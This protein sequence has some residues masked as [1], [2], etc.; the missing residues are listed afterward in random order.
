VKPAQAHSLLNTIRGAAENERLAWDKWEAWYEADSFNYEGEPIS[1]HAA[2]FPLEDGDSDLKLQ[3]NYPYA[4]LDT[5]V[6]TVCPQNPQVTISTTQEASKEAAKAREI[7]INATFKRGNLHDVLWDSSTQTGICGRCPIKTVWSTSRQMPISMWVNP[8]AFFFDMS[9]PYKYT[10]YVCE[11]VCITK[12]E[13]D[14]RKSRDSGFKYNREV[15]KYATGS[16]YPSWL[17][18]MRGQM[19]KNQDD[20]A[21]DELEWVLIYEFYDFAANQFFHFL[22]DNDQPLLHLKE[23]P[24]KYVRNPYTLQVFNKS[25]RNSGGVSD[26]KLIAGLLDRLNE[27]ETIE[28]NHAH[29][30]YPVTLLNTEGLDDPQAAIDA[31]R[32]AGPDD[33]VPMGVHDSH[34]FADV[35]ASTATGAGPLPG[36]AVMA[37]KISGKMDFIL[38]TP[39]YARGKTGT[40]DVATELALV[41]TATRTRNGRREKIMSDV[42]IDIAK[43][44]GGLWQQF[45]PEK[46]QIPIKTDADIGDVMILDRESLGF[47]DPSIA[48]DL[49][50]ENAWEETWYFDFDVVPFSPT[51]NHRLVQLNKLQTFLPYLAQNPNVNKQKFDLKLLELLGM[52]ELFQPEGAQM[53]AAAMAQ[54]QMGATPQMA[55]ATAGGGSLPAG[56]MSDTIS[57]GAMPDGTLDQTEIDPIDSLAMAQQPNAFKP[58][59]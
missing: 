27:I 50:G 21:R 57:T 12:S 46:K 3:T 17:K 1:P 41:D 19:V 34:K 59:Y 43:K 18:P 42:V 45:L 15:A 53:Q 5:M 33:L 52:E 20:A 49:Q 48:A 16:G 14:R 7:L 11:A 22:E 24:Y 54:Q 39:Q 38:G 35:V 32:E 2:V 29:K 30:S 37:E 25:L 31:F 6:A 9:V 51:E 23:L 4:F 56:D 44:T 28:L 55:A 8:R 26:I 10:R 40:S 58:S 47:D 36:F 13:F